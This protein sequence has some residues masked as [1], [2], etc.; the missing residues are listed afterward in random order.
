MIKDRN[1]GNRLKDMARS[2]DNNQ[3]PLTGKHQEARGYT[4]L[5]IMMAVGLITILA[6]MAMPNYQLARKAALETGVIEGLKQLSEAEEIYFESYGY[7]TAGHDQFHDLRKISAIDTK[8]YNR[9]AGRRGVFIKGYSI[10]MVNLGEYPQNYSIVAWPVERGMDL[11]TF[12]IIGDGIV[13][14]T[15][16]METVTIY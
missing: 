16:E 7:Y 14:D 10:Q 3:E 2:P 11:K 15:I 12:F 6:V 9:M 1:I 8:A 5:E 13:R 4:M